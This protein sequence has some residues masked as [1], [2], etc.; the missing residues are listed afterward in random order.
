[1]L[2]QDMS[3]TA[4]LYWV[5][6][7]QNVL[8][9]NRSSGVRAHTARWIRKRQRSSTSRS[10]PS[11]RNSGSYDVRL[12]KRKCTAPAPS[13]S[14]LTGNVNLDTKE[15]VSA[16]VSSVKV[17]APALTTPVSTV[18]GGLKITSFKREACSDALQSISYCQFP[19]DTHAAD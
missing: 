14:S 5:E 16:K 6:C 2:Q 10:V 19:A 9:P 1:M 12:P 7:S 8:I 15:E 13:Q 11:L 4:Q 18:F 3:N 17:H